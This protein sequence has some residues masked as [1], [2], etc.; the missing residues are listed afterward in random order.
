[1]DI[2]IVVPLYNE[3]DNLTPLHA[4]IAKA[5]AELGR[6]YEVVFVDDGSRDATWD[7]LEDLARRAGPSGVRRILA[8]ARR[9]R[10]EAALRA[11]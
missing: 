5:L 11:G 6:S 10:R 9:H 4:E 1:M 2:S 8:D 3:R 7:V